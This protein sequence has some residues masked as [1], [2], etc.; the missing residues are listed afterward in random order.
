MTDIDAV[1]RKLATS[2]TIANCFADTADDH[3]SVMI[4]RTCSVAP[5]SPKEHPMSDL[6][7]LVERIEAATPDQQ[8][9][10]LIE[11]WVAVH[12]PKPP[13]IHGGTPE[14]TAWLIAYNPFHAMLDVNAYESAALT[15]VQE[16]C[17]W[18]VDSHYNMAGVFEY[19]MD[20]QEGPSMSEYGGEGSTPALA[21]CCAALRARM[22]GGE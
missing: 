11:A 14:L 4:R 5:A 8:R 17:Q 20:Q 19:Y 18:R 3:G 10:L 9:E 2:P 7:T 15:L 6:N 1:V 22:G 13:R 12:G 16:G 21:L